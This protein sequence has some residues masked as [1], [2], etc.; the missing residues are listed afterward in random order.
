[1]KT[2]HKIDFA[3]VF[4]SVFALIFLV[5]YVRPL[6]I[7]PIDNYSTSETT[8]L[9]SI[10]NADR[11]LIDDNADFTTPEEYAVKDGAEINLEPGEYYWKAVGV[12]NSEV[13]T[14]KIMSEVNL[15]MRDSGEG[16]YEIVNSGNVR[17]NVEVY[18]GS[19]LVENVKLGIG[20]ERLS[21]GD[22]FVGG[23]DE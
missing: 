7:A 15:E 14:L 11:I 2:V 23:Q 18:N 4:V 20:E 22:K 1:M 9:F 6:V 21:G 12:G 5:G 13:R 17:L 16:S 3:V 10:E 19:N 8:V